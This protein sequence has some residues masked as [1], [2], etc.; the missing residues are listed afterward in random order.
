MRNEKRIY[1]RITS[2]T[3]DNDKWTIAKDGL[4][5]CKKGADKGTGLMGGGMKGRRDEGEAG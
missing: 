5:T 1:S 2:P 4:L 3:W